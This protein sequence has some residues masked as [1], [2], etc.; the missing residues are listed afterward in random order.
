MNNF[1]TDFND[2][3]FIYLV[4]LTNKNST[5]LLLEISVE[6]ILRMNIM[7]YVT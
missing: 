1:S 2:W 5:N 4:G 3:N 7:K 6:H